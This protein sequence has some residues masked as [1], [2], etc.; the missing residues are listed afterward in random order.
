MLFENCETWKPTL[1]YTVV[2]TSTP[3]QQLSFISQEK[4]I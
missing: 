3:N 2:I 1:K 4:P